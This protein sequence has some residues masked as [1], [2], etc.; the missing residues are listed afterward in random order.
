MDIYFDE[1]GN[2]GSVKSN[3]N[4]LNYDNQRHFALCGVIME[5]DDDKEKLKEK[6]KALK[7]EFNILGELKGN[8]LL[9]RDNNE[10]LNVFI[11]EIL[12]DTHFQINI[13][14]KNFYLLTKM[15]GGLLG[16]EFKEEFPLQF[17][18]LA[19]S[20]ISE[21]DNILLKYCQLEENLTLENLKVFLGFL[22]NYSYSNQENLYLPQMVRLILENE[23]EEDV[24]DNLIGVS[25]YIGT[26]SKNIV[27]LSTLSEFIFMLKHEA[28]PTLRNECLNINHDKIDG[29]SKVFQKELAPYGINLNFIDSTD[30]IFIQIADNVASIYCKVINQMVSIFENNKQWDKDSEWMLE[31]TSKLFNKINTDNIKFTLP[32]QNWAVALCVKDM[33]S[34]SY[35]KVNRTNLHFNNLYLS[36]IS[37][38]FYETDKNMGQNVDNLL[39]ILQ[40]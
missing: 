25:K 24:L 7:E 6:Y 37:R 31:L 10:L 3:S 35:P 29:F 21:N 8:S 40:R 33:F 5:N 30:S 27:N 19:S 2:T 15:L 23:L 26:A 32:I 22:A 13:Y 39:E 12:D 18:Q 4:R 38:I 16:V 17:Y 11:D 20:L 9:T 36:N 34:L 1:S 28:G 14:D